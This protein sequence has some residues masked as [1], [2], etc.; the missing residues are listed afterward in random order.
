MSVSACWASASA[1]TSRIFRTLLPPNAK[2]IASSRFTSRRGPPP[3]A[4]R[5]R[6]ISSTGVGAG[7]NGT[8]GNE[9]SA[10]NT[11]VMIV[12]AILS[13]AS[14]QR[15]RSGRPLFCPFRIRLMS[16]CVTSYFTLRH[17]HLSRSCHPSSPPSFGPRARSWPPPRAWTR[18]LIPIT[19]SRASRATARTSSSRIAPSDSRRKTTSAISSATSAAPSRARASRRS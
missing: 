2:P 13:R 16:C 6:V 1:A 5:S 12:E 9:A 4:P 11:T 14:R 10:P 7:A 19:R 18:G 3:R 8:D 17:V 15:R